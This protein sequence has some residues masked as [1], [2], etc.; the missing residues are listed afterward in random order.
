MIQIVCGTKGKGKTKVLLEKANE[1]AKSSNGIT[2][3]LDKNSKHSFELNSLARLI[4]ISEYPVKSYDSFVGFVSGILSGNHDIDTIFF[5]S[6]LTIA[7]IDA[8][9][10]ENAVNTLL[11]IDNT[12]NYF[13]S[14]SLDEKEI[15]ES[16]KQYITVSL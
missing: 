4:D 14:I 5:D 12:C 3:Y 2:V 13:L 8:D 9:N 10:L 1:I 6:F 16:L 15:P 7:S 11:K